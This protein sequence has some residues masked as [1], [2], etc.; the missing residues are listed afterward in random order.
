[1]NQKVLYTIAILICLIFV[2]GCSSGPSPASQS[3]ISSSVAPTTTPVE[4]PVTTGT[5]LT[6]NHTPSSVPSPS[7]VRTFI[8]DRTQDPLVGF[9]DR[10]L[11]TLDNLQGAKEGLLLTYQTGDMVR[12][13]QKAEELSLMVRRNSELS[14]VPTKMDYVRLNYYDYIDQT[15][16]FAKNFKE[17]ADRYLA[18]DKASATSLFQAGIMTADRAD[19]SDKR[20]RTFLS[21]HVHPVQINQT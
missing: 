6:A 1:M 15:G 14:D 21:E 10:V 9:Q 2:A 5:P 13:Q 12:V 19:I 16:Q 7:P 11:L 20:I 8:P 3:Q 4:L 17:A 18:S